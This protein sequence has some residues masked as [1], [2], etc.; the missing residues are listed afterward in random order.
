VKKSHAAKTLEI[1]LIK[2]S[3]AALGQAWATR[4]NGFVGGFGIFSQLLMEW[5][6]QS[7]LTAKMP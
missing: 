5:F 4:L 7:T 3:P 1:A 2:A 6:D